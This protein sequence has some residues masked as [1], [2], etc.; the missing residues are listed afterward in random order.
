M[1]DGYDILDL[2]CSSIDQSKPIKL[3]SWSRP[4]NAA[5]RYEARSSRVGWHNRQRY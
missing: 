5:L 2:Q 1:A 3:L 4:E